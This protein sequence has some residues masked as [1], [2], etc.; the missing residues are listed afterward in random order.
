MTNPSNFLDGLNNRK[1][2]KKS[3]SDSTGQTNA[4]KKT[5]VLTLLSKELASNN[6]GFPS[7]QVTGF[8]EDMNRMHSGKS[9]F[10]AICIPFFSVCSPYLRF[11]FKSLRPASVIITSEK[12]LHYR[13]YRWAQ[14]LHDKSQLRSQKQH[15]IQT[16][17]LIQFLVLMTE[18]Q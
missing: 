8:H 1:E 18:V 12:I 4:I 3:S 6:G 17:S 10:V 2:I 11:Q 16:Y 13:S 5:H 9:I 15:F 14:A 7:L